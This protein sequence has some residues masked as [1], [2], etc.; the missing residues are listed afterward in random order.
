VI[1]VE[2]ESVKSVFEDGPDDVSG[3]EASHGG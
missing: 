1:D 2:E 3:K